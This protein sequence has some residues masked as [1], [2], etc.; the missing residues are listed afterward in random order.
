MHIARRAAAISALSRERRRGYQRE[1]RARARE[2]DALHLAGCMLYWAEGAKNRNALA[3][4]N[5]D[6]EM[7][8]LFVRFLRRSLGVPP[9]RLRLRLNVYLSDG[10]LLPK[11]EEHWLS[12]LDLPPSCL[13]GHTV[14]H[15]PTSSSGA[16]KGALPNGVCSIRVA[17]STPLVQHIFGAIQEYGGFE[18]PEWL[19]CLPGK[20]GSRGSA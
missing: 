5:S 6:V 1:G 9:E 16:K 2:G 12:V 4:A 19:D 3:F 7:M 18:E 15:H 8:K 14:N 20:R 10:R 11:V 13:R 17:R